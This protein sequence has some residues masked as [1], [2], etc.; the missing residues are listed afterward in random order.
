MIVGFVIWSA[1]FLLLLG[2]GLW[3]LKS[4]KTVGFFAGVN[5]P[6]VKDPQKY[7]YAVAILWFVYTFL[8]E[9]LG[10]P[11]LFLRQ[12]AA[13]LLWIV[14]GVALLSIGLMLGYQRILS[15]F[16]EKS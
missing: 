10:L 16:E 15:H 2:I 3:A 1:V 9:L 4:K 5:P 6:K 8:F 13:T 7:N 11:F 14:P 12:N